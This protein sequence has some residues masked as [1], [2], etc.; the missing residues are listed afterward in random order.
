MSVN[1]IA[2]AGRIIFIISIVLYGGL[3]I[4]GCRGEI[5]A[6]I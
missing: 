1:A 5:A 6:Y 2:V 3:T 4:Y